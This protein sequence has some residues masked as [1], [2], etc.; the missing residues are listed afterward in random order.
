M[1]RLV[2]PRPKT[3][4][5]SYHHYGTGTVDLP[6]CCR[7]RISLIHLLRSMQ[8]Q[9]SITISITTPARSSI[10]SHRMAQRDVFRF[11]HVDERIV[12]A[13]SDLYAETRFFGPTPSAT[14]GA[15]ALARRPARSPPAWQRRGVVIGVFLRWRPPCQAWLIDL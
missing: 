8:I 2:L 10:V 6:S 9:R 7:R 3:P 4:T 13:G 15:T 5:R 1:G 14:P 11:H 12:C